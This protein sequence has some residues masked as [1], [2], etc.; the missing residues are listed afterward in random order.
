MKLIR[1]H[2]VPIYFSLF[3]C[4]GLNENMHSVI[5]QVAWQVLPHVGAMC[6][7][8]LIVY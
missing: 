4:E 1:T 2:Q 5:S 3:Q 6:S 8:T 7:T